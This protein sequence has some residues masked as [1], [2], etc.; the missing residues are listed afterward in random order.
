MPEGP[1]ILILKEKLLPFKGKKVIDA[2][3]YAKGF[4]AD[5][6]IGKTLKDIKTWGKHTLL[7]FPK[8]TVRV[9]L[10]LFGSY[11]INDRPKKNASLHMQF[12]N[13]EVNFSISSIKLIEEPLDDLYDWS[14]DIMS[15]KWDDDKA[16]A[17]LKAKPKMMICDALLDQKIFSGSGNIIKNESLFRAH[18]H[19]ESVIGEIPDAKLKDLITEV[20]KFSGEFLKYRKA[21][22]LIKHLEAYEKDICPRNL[23]PFHKTD[24]GKTKRHS[25][26]CEKCQ[27]LFD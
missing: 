27:E 4:D 19:P 10:M 16:L 6:L 21:G 8:F 15:R 22:T 20:V 18:L 11:Y 24:T 14:A 1:S 13:G 2:N 23:I 9:H 7:C 3:G 25:Y 12:A 26:Y 5:M 17:K